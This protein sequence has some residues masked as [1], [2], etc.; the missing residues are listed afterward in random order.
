M[1][2]LTRRHSM[3]VADSILLALAEAPGDRTPALVL[4]DWLEE[5]DTPATRALAPLVRLAAEKRTADWRKRMRAARATLV[6]RPL[7]NSWFDWWF[8]THFGPTFRL[9]HEP[10]QVA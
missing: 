3:N 9:I 7:A 4:A 5:Q 8:G 10:D 1:Q 2:L 6:N